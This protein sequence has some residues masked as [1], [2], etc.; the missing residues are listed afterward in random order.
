MLVEDNKWVFNY[1]LLPHPKSLY[2]YFF[3]YDQIR[4]KRN[5]E[6]ADS[7]SRFLAF[8]FDER[9]TTPIF[10]FANIT[11][12]WLK[13]EQI[14]QLYHVKYS[15][16]ENDFQDELDSYGTIFGLSAYKKYI[17]HIN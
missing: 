11:G 7:C 10:F 6:N 14:S 2:E 4:F 8:L 17:L 9:N 3:N 16:I 13:V 5:K 12:L 1:G 15:Q